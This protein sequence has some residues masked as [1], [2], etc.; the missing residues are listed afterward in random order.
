LRAL[1]P[2]ARGSPARIAGVQGPRQRGP[3]RRE[4]E[5]MPF[6][7][8]VRYLMPGDHDL[9]DAPIHLPVA[10]LPRAPLVHAEIDDVQPVAHV[11]EHQARLAAVAADRAGFPERVNVVQ[12]DLLAPDAPGCGGEAVFF[13]RRR[14]GEQRD[15]TI[16]RTDS[17]LVRGAEMRRHQ[18]V[19]H[20]LTLPARA[21]PGQPVVTGERL[22]ASV[23][24]PAQRRTH[25]DLDRFQ[26][27]LDPVG[28]TARRYRDISVYL[29]RLPAK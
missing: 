27:E 28:G 17:G 14:C 20:A 4:R 18:P 24:E 10:E 15:V 29:P 2:G 12:L 22:F 7:R 1:A 3:Q 13:R 19:P 23:R 21:P 16:G 6:F 11:V 8:Q 5:L 26:V 25:R 9:E